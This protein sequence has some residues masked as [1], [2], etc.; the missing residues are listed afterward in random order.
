MPRI[1][2]SG[3]PQDDLGLQKASAM[4]RG[5]E[6]GVAATAE[7]HGFS[8][9]QQPVHLPVT[10]ALTSSGKI[11]WQSDLHPIEPGDSSSYFRKRNG[12]LMAV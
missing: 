2:R 5:P 3:L 10:S 9:L 1:R 8:Q 4:V 6:K 7:G 12:P 11:T